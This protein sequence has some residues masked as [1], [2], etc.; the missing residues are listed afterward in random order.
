L[1]E[2]FDEADTEFEMAMKLDP[3]SFEA[4]YFYARSCVAQGRNEDA[5]KWFERATTVRPDDY[6][7]LALLA[8]VYSALGQHDK[9][10]QASRRAYDT[11]RK[12]LELTPDDPR[13]LYMG[14]MS[15]TTLGESEK[16]REWNRRALAMDP[17]D[18][19]VLYNIACAFAMES[20]TTEALEALTKA[21]DNGFG[22]WKWIEHDSDIDSLRE[23][24]GFRDLLKRKPVEA[25]V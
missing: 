15:L 4:A 5:A 18:P 13:A 9:S 24:D 2:R 11:A 8:T 23:T 10:I 22:H 17:D 25:P 21:L 14:A 16:A 7:S 3:K 19:S 12:H 6:A 1:S 20:Q